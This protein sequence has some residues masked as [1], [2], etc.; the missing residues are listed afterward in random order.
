MENICS[1]CAKEPGSHSF[2]YLCKTNKTEL[3]EY[4]FYT[5]VGEAKKYKDAEGIVEHYTKCLNLM[6]PDKWIWVINADGI[7]AKHYTELKTIKRLALLVKN[8][9]K[10]ENIFVV[11]AP[12]LLDIVL[13]I[14]K[15]ILDKET[16]GKIKVIK[17]DNLIKKIDLSPDDKNTLNN[18]L[19]RKYDI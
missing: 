18:M 3:F 13:K 15:P 8:Y 10:V 17:Q 16:F 7:S 2:T 11:N 19:I 6:N 9:G 12:G 1:V 5:C 4:V 14:V